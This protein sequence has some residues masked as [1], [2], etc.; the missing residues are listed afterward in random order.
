[1]ALVAPQAFLLMLSPQQGNPPG[2]YNSGA[3]GGGGS[4]SGTVNSGLMNQLAYYV[5]DGTTVGGNANAT[6]D[7]SGNV[8]V[9][10]VTTS[11]SGY[12]KIAGQA[13]DSCSTS[14]VGEYWRAT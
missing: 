9:A 12:S 3:S 6:V 2:A 1:M 14:T 10:S 13:D 8:T 4:G 5:A 11:G 7:S